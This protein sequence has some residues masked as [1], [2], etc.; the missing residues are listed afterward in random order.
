[1]S[2]LS[3]ILE[4]KRREVAAAKAQ[5]PAASVAVSVGGGR[6]RWLPW[7][8]GQTN[9][10]S[11]WTTA[12]AIGR[13]VTSS[14]TWD[15]SG[16]GAHSPAAPGVGRLKAARTIRPVTGPRMRVDDRA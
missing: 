12:P 16:A 5:R 11:S 10:R 15:W 2:I 4:T 8:A 3:R 1:M 7:K 6:C 9:S 13:P 14:S